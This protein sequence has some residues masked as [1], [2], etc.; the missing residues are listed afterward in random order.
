MGFRVYGADGGY[1]I[2]EYRDYRDNGKDK[3][4]YY[5]GLKVLGVLLAE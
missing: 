4:N 2:G 5:L 1:N 3:G